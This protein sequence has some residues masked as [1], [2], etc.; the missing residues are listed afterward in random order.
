MA[1]TTLHHYCSIE[2]FISIVS[3]RTI[4]LSL[5]SQSN[6]TEEGRWILR[7]LK[8]QIDQDKELLPIKDTLIRLIEGS[9]QFLSFG[10]FCLSEDGDLL[11]QWRGYADNGQGVA[12]GFSKSYLEKLGGLITA[13][14]SGVSL[15]PVNYGDPDQKSE[16]IELLNEILERAKRLSKCNRGSLLLPA[17]EDEKK[18]YDNANMSLIIS[19]APLMLIGHKY[20]NPA[21]SEEKEWRLMSITFPFGEVGLSLEEVCDFRSG[22]NRLVPYRPVPLVKA[23]EKIIDSIVLGPRN[24]SHVEHVSAL[25]RKHGFHDV[26]VSKSS[27][28]YRG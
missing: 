24:V 22:G 21:F 10:G 17:T 18:E 7:F 16:V 4:R 25:L 15:S 26:E 19:S 28:T 23:E 3:S 9:L 6:D 5:L 11:S 1:R 2:A 20:K 13:E 12:I 8:Q 27:A 14:G